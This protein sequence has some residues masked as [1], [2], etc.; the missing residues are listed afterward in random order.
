[1]LD[2]DDANIKN[3]FYLRLRAKGRHYHAKVPVLNRLPFPSIA[4]ISFLVMVNLA[5]W[6]AVGIVLV[7]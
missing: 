5:I 1:M 7:S 4:I 3:A 2:S 6:I